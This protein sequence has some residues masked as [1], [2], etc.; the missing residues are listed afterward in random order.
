ML[1]QEFT[2]LAIRFA[3]LALS[4]VSTVMLARILGSR[5][6]GEYAYVYT[7]V[8]VLTIPS[9]FGLPTLLM[10]EVA[11]ME[12]A[13]RWSLLRGLL[14]RSHQAV[15]FVSALAIILGV[16]ATELIRSREQVTGTVTMLWGFALLPALAFESVCSAC[17]RGL[18][19]PF[20]GTMANQ[21]VRP[22]LLVLVVAMGTFGF[23]AV[24]DAEWAMAAHVFAAY[25][26]YA[27][28]L[29]MLV[30]Y[31]P[32]PVWTAKGIYQDR[33]WATSAVHLSLLTGIQIFNNQ[34]DVLLL[35][36]LR[37]TDQVGIYRAA[38]QLSTLG[39]MVLTAAGQALG[40][41]IAVLHASG[42]RRGLQR[43]LSHLAGLSVAAIAPLAFAYFLAGDTLMGLAFGAEFTSGALVLQILMVGQLGVAFTGCSAIFLNMVGLEKVTS[44]TI[45]IAAVLN[46]ALNLLLIPRIGM[47]GSAIGNTISYL[48]WSVGLLVF[49]RRRFGL[50]SLPV[51]VRTV[52]AH[53]G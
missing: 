31:L 35:G 37:S 47:V 25:A 2:S 27:Y 44:L 22:A 13:A 23:R 36:A 53:A 46:I 28:G 33:S 43:I 1:A 38:V 41:H 14:V 52:A 30:R 4:F 3:G 34:V 32:R 48:F 39:L 51:P 9:Q 12:A 7:I 6:Y 24:F 29:W 18:R 19:R 26:A 15:A 5:G 11:N 8:T 40:P 10:R 21:V 50:W 45:L 49:I 42:D 20:E 16:V 17:L